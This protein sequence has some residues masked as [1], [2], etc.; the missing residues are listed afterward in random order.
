MESSQ[1][2]TT[3]AAD[4]TRILIPADVE[5]W[6][7]QTGR[8]RDVPSTHRRPG[9]GWGSHQQHHAHS[10]H[11]RTPRPD[12]W[13]YIAGPSPASTGYSHH[14]ENSTV[15]L[16]L[17]ILWNTRLAFYA[18]IWL[19]VMCHE[20]MYI[21]SLFKWRLIIR[22]L[23]HGYSNVSTSHVCFESCVNIC[24]KLLHFYT[25]PMYYW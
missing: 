12:P 4:I 6:E 24:S 3:H 8:R 23:Y 7:S 10:V 9:H 2:A 22:D 1:E 15:V 16:Y 11:S 21:T 5:T 25:W 13:S 14:V 20:N 19:V 18:T 17:A